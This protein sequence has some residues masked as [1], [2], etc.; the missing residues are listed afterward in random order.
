[1]KQLNVLICIGSLVLTAFSGFTLQATADEP[2][3]TKYEFVVVGNEAFGDLVSRGEYQ[4][5]IERINGRP[6]AYPFATATNLCVSFSMIGQLDR[7]ATQCDE[8]LKQ[9]EASSLPGPK[10][11]NTRQQLATSW[12]IAYSNRGVFRALS[13]DLSG[14][15]ADFQ[16]AV[17]HEAKMNA[18]TRNFARVQMKPTVPAV[19]SLSH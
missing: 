14:A 4:L 5:A 7:A 12:A 10:R 19:A 11:W 9:A 13:G 16:M 3:Q 6:K 18:P 1:M 17:E 2:A 15:A 8:A